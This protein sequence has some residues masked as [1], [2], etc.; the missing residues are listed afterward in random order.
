MSIN[1]ARF[2]LIGHT[3]VI[4]EIPEYRSDPRPDF[5]VFRE[6]GWGGTEGATASASEENL[7]NYPGSTGSGNYGILIHEFAHAIHLL[8]LNTLDPAFDVR[9]RSAYETAVERGLWQGTYASSDR[10]EYW[11][12]GTHAWFFPKGSASFRRYGHTRQALKEYDPGLA[13]LLAEVYGDTG[14]RYIRPETRT[15]LSH[16]EGFDPQGSPTFQWWPELVELYRQFSTDPSSDGGGRWVNLES[17]DPSSLP[18][19]TSRTLGD[20]TSIGFVNSSESDVLL[21]WA[22]SDGSTGGYWTRARPGEVRV[23][24]TRV[25]RIWIVRDV[26]GKDLAVFLAERKTSRAIVGG[27]SP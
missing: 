25:S 8:G 22:H 21:Y 2:S 1:K 24:P 6:R 9:L 5:I 3:E 19:L 18:H 15:H 16:L 14:W 23:T 20:P 10:R 7:L 11:A 12:E 17:Y 13:A 26:R 4:S 27:S